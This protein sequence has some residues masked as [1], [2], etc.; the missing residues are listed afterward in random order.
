MQLSRPDGDE[1]PHPLE[2]QPGMCGTVDYRSRV[3]PPPPLLTHP[4]EM[5]MML[6]L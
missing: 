2:I 4:Y 1:R 6:W 3:Y 5:G